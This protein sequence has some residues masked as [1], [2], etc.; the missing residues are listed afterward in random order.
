MSMNSS[1]VRSNFNVELFLQHHDPD[2][3]VSAGGEMLVYT[4]Q[5]PVGGLVPPA[6]PAALLVK[7]KVVGR[8]VV[9]EDPTEVITK[10]SGAPVVVWTAKEGDSVE[11]LFASHGYDYLDGAVHAH[12]QTHPRTRNPHT[13]LS[14]CVTK[15]NPTASRTYT[16]VTP[17]SSAVRPLAPMVTGTHWRRCLT[18]ARGTLTRLAS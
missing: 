9:P 8:D 16:Q 12:T 18:V 11:S 4:G 5:G 10:D 3:E 2:D 13:V 14:I 1:R 15:N 17:L 6:G 7:H